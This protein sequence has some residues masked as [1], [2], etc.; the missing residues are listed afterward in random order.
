LAAGI[1][2]KGF[3][4]VAVG[5]VLTVLWAVALMNS[6]NFIDNMDGLCATVGGVICLILALAGVLAGQLLVP[7]LYLVLAGLLVGFLFFNFHPASIFLGD[8]GSLT[9]GYLMAVFSIT[10]TYYGADQPTGLPILIPLAIMG[11]P[12]FDTISVL[13]IRKTAG[14]PLM[15]GDKNHFSHRLQRLGFST[16]QT[17]LTI[18]ALTAATGL[19]SLALRELETVTAL[20]HLSGI[21]LLFAVIGFIE[22]MGRNRE[23]SE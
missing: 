5:G 12:L 6:F 23:R 22:F 16:P 3:L 19:L 10:T 17:V 1:T 8:S 2:I 20:L 9:I 13:I 18:G 21:A 11:V 14:A 4:P 7:A 15:I